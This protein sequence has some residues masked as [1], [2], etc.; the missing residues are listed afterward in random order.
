MKKVFNK[1]TKEIWIGVGVGL[2]AVAY[3]IATMGIKKGAVVSVGAEFMPRVYGFILL[4]V[5]VFQIIGGVIQYRA[6]TAAG[7]SAE[8]SPEEKE[9]SRKSMLPVLLVFA[10]MIVCVALMR[11]L[12]F[13]ISGS[14]LTFCMCVL[15]TPFYEKRRYAI[16]AVFSVVLAVAAY[17]LFKNVLYVS[18]P[19]GI[20]PF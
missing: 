19:S 4:M 7:E 16:F 6:S 18:L 5:S 9:K 20:L 3:L 8:P 12:G 17:L 14:I 13:V 15:L 10:A 1:L 2:F 11:T